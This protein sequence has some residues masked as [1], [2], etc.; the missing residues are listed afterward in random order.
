F[1]SHSGA[2]LDSTKV[3]QVSIRNDT[4]APLDAQLCG[5]DCLSTVQKASILPGES[6]QVNVSAGGSVTRYYLLDRSGAT[7]GC[8]ALRFAKPV[9][10]FTISTSRA[11]K[12]PG[13]PIGA[14]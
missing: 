4:A 7:V 9:S 13:D 12:C 5:S 14:P 2:S 3:F 11:E 6:A 1:A 8:L 10:G